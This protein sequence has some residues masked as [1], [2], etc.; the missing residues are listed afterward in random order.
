VTYVSNIPGQV[1][2]V[3]APP[4]PL[5][6]AEP[7][8]VG[9]GGDILTISDPVAVAAQFFLDI[10]LTAPGERVMRPGYG[11]G[12]RRLVFENAGMTQFR[13]FAAQLQTAFTANN[14]GYANITV[15][16]I[17]R[18]GGVYAFEVNFTIDQSPILHQAVFDAAGN[19]VGS[20]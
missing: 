4:Y 6:I 19:L 7:F 14:N 11:V 17:Q 15:G 18:P 10:A 2:T 16:V 3:T 8:R 20:T 5:E 12:L 1:A 13:Q 9:P